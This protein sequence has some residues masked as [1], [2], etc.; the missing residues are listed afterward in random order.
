[1]RAHGSRTHHDRDPDGDRS[2]SQGATVTRRDFELIGRAITNARSSAAPSTPEQMADAI[3]LAL[4]R[5]L[6]S[7]SA[8]FNVDRFLDACGMK[9][10]Q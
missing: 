9:D 10:E 4:S 2:G 7:E 5:A 3:S 6:A 8:T 1:M